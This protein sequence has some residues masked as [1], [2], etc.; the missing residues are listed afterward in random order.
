MEGLFSTAIP[1]TSLD[2]VSSPDVQ[3]AIARLDLIHPYLSG[4]K[5]FKLW[6]YLEKYRSTPSEGLVTFGG[7][8]SNHLL[9]TAY[10]GHILGIPCTGV[11]RGEAPAIPGPT[12]EDCA[13]YGMKLHYVSR[14]AYK[15]PGAVI[16]AL[17]DGPSGRRESLGRE[18]PS[19]RPLVIPE[20][21][22]GEEGI[23]GAA[24][25]CQKIPGIETFTHI[26]CATGT[27]TTLSGIDRALLPG[28]SAIG[29]PVL[30]IPENRQAG[31]LRSLGCGDRTRLFFGYA[32]GG[33]ARVNQDLIRFMRTFYETHAVPTD[34][35][36]TAKAAF[37]LC[38]LAGQGYFPSG[39][40]ILLIHTGG[41]QGNRSLPP[42]ILGF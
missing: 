12:L 23:R 10:A 3:C 29:I 42:N 6:Y 41:L 37:A 24:L 33:Y 8:Y 32:F 34:F 7:A 17:Y 11:V 19:G 36:Y 22:A 18:T 4:N 1:V 5:L 31:F 2:G 30:K 9:A 27:G 38:D 40:R 13:R 14:Q 26:L 28:Q 25:I 16:G 20:G 15:D 35:V 39:S 21:G